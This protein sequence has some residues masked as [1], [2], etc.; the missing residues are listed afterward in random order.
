MPSIVA[1]LFPVKYKFCVLWDLARY[2][3]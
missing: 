1:K 2:G 3:Y